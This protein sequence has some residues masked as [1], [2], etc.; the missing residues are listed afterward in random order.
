MRALAARAASR[1]RRPP[2]GRVRLQQAHAA[3]GARERR[4]VL[5][6]RQPRDQ[7]RIR[8]RM[9]GGAQLHLVRQALRVPRVQGGVSLAFSPP[10]AWTAHRCSHIPDT[11]A[12]PWRTCHESG[13]VIQALFCWSALTKAMRA[14]GVTA[15]EACLM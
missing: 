12:Q 10:L 13:A 5:V 8:L 3:C 6:L 4:P 1:W 9:R 7:V 2:R 11:M 15:P 14:L